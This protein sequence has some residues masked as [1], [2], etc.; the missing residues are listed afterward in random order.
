MNGGIDPMQWSRHSQIRRMRALDQSGSHDARL[1]PNASTV[2]ITRK[3]PPRCDC[4]LNT[5]PTL[6]CDRAGVI[7]LAWYI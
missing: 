4:V 2:G 6:F 1:L 5:L 3:L 7:G